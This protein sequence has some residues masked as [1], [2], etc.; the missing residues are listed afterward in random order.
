[1][2]RTACPRSVIGDA[3]RLRQVLLNLAGNAIKF[4]ERG[5]V[6][7]H[8]RARRS[9]P[10]RSASWCATPASASRPRSRRASFSSSSRPTA[11]RRAGSAAPA[12]GSPSPSASSSAWAAASASRARPGAGSTFHVAVP[13]PRAPAQDDGAHS[14]RPILPAC[15]VL[16]VAPAAIE[17]VAGGAA[18]D[19]LGRAHLRGARRAGRAGAAAR[20][21]LERDPGRPRARRPTA[22]ERAGATR[23][24]R[25]SRAAS[26]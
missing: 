2:S 8:R 11:A 24:T 14:R 23:P 18:A 5:G 25:R 17:A 16:I 13:L 26:C 15:D 4:T 21:G 10:T 1:M 19:A 20:A 6:A 22:C 9:R 7:H 12:S 3:A